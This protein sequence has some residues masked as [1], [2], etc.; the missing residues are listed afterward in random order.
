LKPPPLIEQFL[1]RPK[2]AQKYLET[3]KPAKNIQKNL[4]K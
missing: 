4:N 2:C 3:G 1:K